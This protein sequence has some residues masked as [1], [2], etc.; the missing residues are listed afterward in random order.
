[1]T[2]VVERLKAAVDADFGLARDSRRLTT[3]VFFVI[4]GI[5]AAAQRR[6]Y[7]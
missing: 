6:S 5:Y 2:A 7:K 3:C 4:Y 1:M